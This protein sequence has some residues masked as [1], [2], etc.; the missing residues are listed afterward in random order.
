MTYNEAQKKAE[1]YAENGQLLPFLHEN[2][3]SKHIPFSEIF[4]VFME[5]ASK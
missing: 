4:E 5:E 2:S 3:R 1:L